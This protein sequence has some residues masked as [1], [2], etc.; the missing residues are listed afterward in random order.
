VLRTCPQEDSVAYYD[1]TSFAACEHDIDSVLRREEARTRR[2]YNRNND[3]GCLVPYKEYQDLPWYKDMFVRTLKAIDIENS[4]PRK[5][6]GLQLPLKSGSLCIIRRNDAKVLALVILTYK[7]N[8]C[9][10]FMVILGKECN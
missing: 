2:A 7:M 8:N 3:I 6:L 4:F 1:H 5:I 10:Y 9:L